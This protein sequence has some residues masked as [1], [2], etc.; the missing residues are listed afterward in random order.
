MLI[1]NRFVTVDCYDDGLRRTA[2]KEPCTM[3]NM[4]PTA[5]KLAGL[6]SEGERIAIEAMATTEM[7]VMAPIIE[8]SVAI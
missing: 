2:W 1:D 4:V 5:A 7:K 3:T 6:L 8:G